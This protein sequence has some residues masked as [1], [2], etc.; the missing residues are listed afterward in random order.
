MAPSATNHTRGRMARVVLWVVP[1]PRIAIVL[2]ATDVLLTFGDAPIWVRLL[3]GVLVHAA[4][5][6]VRWLP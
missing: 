4:V 5:H 3:V 2:V 6:L 1:S